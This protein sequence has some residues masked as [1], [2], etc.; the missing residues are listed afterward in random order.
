MQTGKEWKGANVKKNTKKF[1]AVFLLMWTVVICVSCNSAKVHSEYSPCLVDVQLQS[2]NNG[3][4]ESQFV[5]VDLI[6]DREIAVVSEKFENLKILIAGN[7]IK[8][9]AYTLEQGEDE[10]TARITISV[11]AV[12]T[13]VLSL[14]K[15]DNVISEIRSADKKYSVQDFSVETII[16]SGVSLSTVESE[17]GKVVKS[18]DS[19]WNIRSIAWIGIFENGELVEGTQTQ[20]LESLDGYSAV[21]GHEFLVEN[22]NTIAK[23]IVDVLEK[24]YPSEYGFC[25]D[26]NRITI[27]KKNSLDTLDLVIYQYTKINQKNVE[28]MGTSAET[29]VQINK[30]SGDGIKTKQEIQDREMTAEE[31]N[32]WNKLHISKLA[33]SEEGQIV[34]GN[35]LYQTLTITGESMPEEQI[36][37]VRDLEDLIQLSFENEK[38]NQLNLPICEDGLYGFDFL[39]F[40]EFCGVDWKEKNLNLLAETQSGEIKTISYQEVCENNGKLW[41]IFAD[42]GSY[43]ELQESELAL[44]IVQNNKKEFICDVKKVLVGAEKTPEDPKY[45]YHNRGG[46]LESQDVEFRMEIYQQNAEYLGAIKTITITTEEIEQMMCDHPEMVVRNYYGTIG[47]E[48][49]FSYMGTGGWLDYF[50]GINLSWLLSE[51]AEIESLEGYAELIGRD[52]E[53]YGKI[54]DLQYLTD[55][56]DKESYYILTKDGAKITGCIPMIACV[57]NGYPILPEHDHESDL[58]C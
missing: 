22:E 23:E 7:R 5:Q 1:V 25:C 55:S 44:V 6:F 34:D 3:S 27:E 54:E 38:M 30:E 50:E 21:H 52:G 32:F 26:K 40:L 19:S 48:E 58:F 15:T 11:Q 53:V 17:V 24:N 39:R 4:E 45:R 8:E 56:Q 16:P 29:E 20:E 10:N 31:Q 13:G 28:A 36:Y 12:T 18:V 35:A 33:S 2:Y 46:Y 43:S 42:D 47:N 41:L 57:K 49:L 14:E 37:S 51:K 9:D